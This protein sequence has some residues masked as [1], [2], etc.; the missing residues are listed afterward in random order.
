MNANKTF[1]LKQAGAKGDGKCD[2]TATFQN[3]LEL[4]AESQGTIEVPAG[5]YCVGSLKMHPY[6]GITG[7]PTY[8]WKG[9]AGSVLRLV[10]PEAKSL[11][12]ITLAIGARVQGI[13]LDGQD[14]GKGIHGILV[15]KPDFGVTED[16]TVIDGCK[17][18]NF[19]GDG[20]HLRRIWCYRVR[21]CMLGNNHGHGLAVEGWDGFVLDN[22]LSMNR[23]AGFCSI[24]ENNAV[25]MIGNRIEFNQA[26]GVKI[27][28]GS[29]YNITGNYFDRCNPGIFFVRTL[30]HKPPTGR[31]VGR[32]GYSTITGNIL[33]R[34][35]HPLWENQDENSRAHIVLRGVRGVA[36]TGNTLVVG[37]DDYALGGLD[38]NPE[39]SWSPDYGIIADSLRNVIIKDNNMDSGA[40]KKLILDYGSHG[41]G[42]MIKDNV[43]E[44]FEL[45]K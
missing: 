36:V 13:C 4:A 40:I 11:L 6:T 23:G 27:L 32:V 45:E 15:A 39:P 10:D 31:I 17:I 34:S 26:G 42:V 28:N 43:G 25:T 1:N 22:W 19:T 33:Y 20:V 3:L 29:H 14:I 18:S 44:L 12:D 24:G 5:T 37:G 9:F 41:P 30:D 21:G 38:K 8:G 2:D 16:S 7:S 35:G